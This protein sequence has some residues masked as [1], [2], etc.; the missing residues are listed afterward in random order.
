MLVRG[1]KSVTWPG[2]VEVGS[3][4]AHFTVRIPSEGDCDVTHASQRRKLAAI[5]ATLILLLTMMPSMAM[6]HGRK[7]KPKPP[8]DIQILGLNDFHGQLEVVDPLASSGGRIGA[9]QGTFPN[10]TCDPT[11]LPQTCVPAGGVEYLATHIRNLT[12]TNRPNTVFVTAGDNIGATP[13]LSALFHDEPTI[14]A[15]NLMGLSLA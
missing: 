12:A 11:I 10:Q 1:R 14:E 8:V 2:A 6:A 3:A 9:L 5:G 7:P 15:L 4:S 13:L